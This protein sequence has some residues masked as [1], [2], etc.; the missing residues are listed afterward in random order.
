M[1]A[2]PGKTDHPYRPDHNGECLDCDEP[3]D[4]HRAGE[5]M[6]QKPLPPHVQK[7]RDEVEAQIQ[8]D[9]DTRT[10]AMDRKYNLLRV[11]ERRWA[12][13]RVASA[14]AVMFGSTDVITF[15]QVT[16]PLPFTEALAALEDHRQK[17]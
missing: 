6:T 9:R 13:I 12:V 15:E 5:G 8:K 14:A 17:R 3:A 1:P 2:G 10:R 16:K 7:A 11:S 4:A